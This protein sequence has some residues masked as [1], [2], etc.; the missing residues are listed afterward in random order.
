LRISQAQ[1]PAFISLA[2]RSTT[3][4]FPEAAISS[5]TIAGV[6]PKQ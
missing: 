6:K 3:V 5:R 2:M 1:R 4:D